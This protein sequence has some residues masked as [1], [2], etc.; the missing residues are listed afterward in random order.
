M[1]ANFYDAP[2]PHES[3]AMHS[4][5][6]G[7][8][9]REMSTYMTDRDAEKMCQLFADGL[10]S[11]VGYARIL[12]FMERQ[13]IDTKMTARLRTAVLE[14]GDRLGEA[15]A[16]FGVL[17]APTRKLV[18]VA[19]EQGSLPAT[20]TEQAKIYGARYKRKRRI[21][22]AMIEPLFM[23]CLGVFFFRNLFNSLLFADSGDF[24]ATLFQML[25][26]S[27][28]QSAILSLFSAGLAYTWIN[29]P[30]DSA[31]R[32]ASGRLWYRLP[33]ISTGMRHQ[34]VANFARFLRQS[35]SSGMDIFR[36][37]ELAAEASN[38]PWL[39]ETVD[40][41]RAVLEDGYPLD[42]AMR[43]LR[44]LP[45]EFIDYVAIGEETGRLEENLL[46]LAERYD[47]KADEAYEM[48]LQTFI[49]ILRFLLVIGIMIFAVF[50]AIQAVMPTL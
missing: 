36:S 3:Q 12:D 5:Q 41:A 24:G 6:G 13:H 26:K 17:D 20:F 15:F 21:V 32:D 29:L 30:V 22:L 48:A 19:E 50:G 44:G 27:G 8:V 37:I 45:D 40:K 1:D 2:P 10:R 42:T 35:M 39:M 7:A 23:I 9:V 28:I 33:F 18:L 34:C 16:R 38:S 49:Y 25:G 14:Y 43:Q 46:F 31:F 4:P 11:G 47:A